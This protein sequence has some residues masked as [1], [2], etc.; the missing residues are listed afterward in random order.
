M[1]TY[2]PITI[3]VFWGIVM[4]YNGYRSFNPTIDDLKRKRDERNR[5]SEFNIEAGRQ[6]QA[7]DE[8]EERCL[9]E[10]KILPK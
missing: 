4:V 9:K 8:W 6:M 2:L 10:G 1:D 3:G 5:Q 7:N